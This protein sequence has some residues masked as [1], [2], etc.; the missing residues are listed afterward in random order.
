MRRQDA[1]LYDIRTAHSQ[2]GQPGR[3][4]GVPRVPGGS[5]RWTA[6]EGVLAAGR[7]HACEE[8]VLDAADTFNV[9]AYVFAEE[10]VLAA[11][12]QHRREGV[13]ATS[14]DADQRDAPDAQGVPDAQASTR[15][16]KTCARQYRRSSH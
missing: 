11:G 6:E 7:R 12:R 10:D 15:S 16:G 1:P 13:S 8:D 4:F 5:R 3:R 9:L 2:H 14:R